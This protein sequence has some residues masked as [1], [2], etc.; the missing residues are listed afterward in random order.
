MA[1]N[2]ELKGRY[3]DLSSAKAVAESLGAILHASETQRDT[4]F[5]ASAGRL[6]LRE[7]WPD[8]ASG[9]S[10]GDRDTASPA[11]ELIWYHRSDEPTARGSDYTRTPVGDADGLRTTL[12][13]ALGVI[14][15]VSKHRTVY[16]LDNVRIH[17]DNVRGL[18]TFL[19]FEA[20]MDATRTEPAEHQKLVDLQRAFHITPT[21]VLSHS[22]SDM[23]ANV[24]F[25]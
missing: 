11:A 4:Y 1:R 15:E 25:A 10:G 9:F 13:G 22:Y 21:D 20:V 17:F 2:I 3:T 12:A 8:P 19:E 7:R 5:R 24:R 16:L 18:G 14:V 23:L 6:K